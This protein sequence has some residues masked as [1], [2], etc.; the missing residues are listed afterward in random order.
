MALPAPSAEDIGFVVAKVAHLGAE[1]HARSNHGTNKLKG[2]RRLAKQQKA[3]EPKKPAK[4]EVT[5]K[6]F[7]IDE[8]RGTKLV[9]AKLQVCHP[10]AH[11]L[12]SFP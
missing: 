4:D 5:S 8:R 2:M 6:R 11:N 7:D 9:L 1:R 10:D 3:P 12:S